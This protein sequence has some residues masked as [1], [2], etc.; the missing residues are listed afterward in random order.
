MAKKMY[1][2]VDGIARKIKKGYLGVDGIARKVK[3][4]YIGVGGKARLFWSGGE[5]AYYGKAPNLRYARYRICGG[6]IGDYALLAA[7]YRNYND[8]GVDAYNRSLT[9]SYPENSSVRGYDVSSATFNGR[10]FFT[11]GDIGSSYITSYDASLVKADINA[12]Y[13]PPNWSGTKY[14]A[15]IALDDC[16]ILGNPYKSNSDASFRHMSIFYHLDK[17]FVLSTTGPYT[18]KGYLVAFG[19]VGNYAVISGGIYNANSSRVTL[20]D[21]VCATDSSLTIQNVSEILDVE[22]RNHVGVSIGKDYLLFAGGFGPDNNANTSALSTVVAYDKS[23]TKI[24]APDMSIARAF[25]KAGSVDEYAIIVG[26]KG[27]VIDTYN[28]SLTRTSNL[29]MSDSRS[30]P[31]VATNGDLILIAGGETDGKY[32]AAVDVFTL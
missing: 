14:T 28:S 7:G 17:E 27:S 22:C 29:S 8:S 9:A 5:L 20:T 18:Y 25:P 6:Y 15:P 10:A 13:D 30:Y 16:L 3:K 23:L 12:N 11:P 21:E 24:Q 2:G 31:S 19:R 32:S 1:L 4:G 26:N